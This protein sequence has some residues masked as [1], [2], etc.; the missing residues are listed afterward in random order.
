MNTKRIPI[1]DRFMAKFAVDDNGCWIWTSAVNGA[2]Y[3]TIGL[4]GGNY[5]EFAHRVSWEIHN[6]MPVPAGKIVCHKCDVRKCVNP[7]HLFIGTHAENTADMLKK[8]R[9]I[10]GCRLTRQPKKPKARL[11]E[12]DVIRIREEY[13][14]GQETQLSIAHRYGVTGTTVQNILQRKTW[15]NV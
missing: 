12:N 5:K 4:P 8:G 7:N 13:V 3:G 9:G 2:G 14:K 15:G 11:T 6:G 1:R 10:T